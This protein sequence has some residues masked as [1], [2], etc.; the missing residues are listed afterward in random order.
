MAG[1]CSRAGQVARTRGSC[2]ADS[3]AVVV[4]ASRRGL[5][6]GKSG[7][8]HVVGDVCAGRGCVCSE[9]STNA[10]S[11]NIMKQKIKKHNAQYETQLKNVRA[12]PDDSSESEEEETEP[13]PKKGGKKKAASDSEE[14][15][16]ESEDSEA[17]AERKAKEEDA[18]FEKMRSKH[19]KKKDREFDVDPEQVSFPTA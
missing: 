2:A 10:K 14:S 19:D 4:G 17:E 13:T 1:R 16:A 8:Y 9:R 11:L 6:G 3:V 5:L 12:N 15:D 7:R 18:K